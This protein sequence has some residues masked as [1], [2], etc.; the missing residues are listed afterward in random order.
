MKHSVPFYAFVCSLVLCLFSKPAVAQVDTS[1]NEIPELVFQNPVLVSGNALK[2]GA[3]Y[4]FTNVAAGIDGNIRLKKFSRSDISMPS[5]DLT[6]LGW[7]KAFQPQFGLPGNVQP[8]QDWYIDFEL[9]FFKSGSNTKEMVDKFTLTALDVD[10]DGLSIKEYVTMEKAS[11]VSYAAN[12]YFNTAPPSVLI[13]PTCPKCGKQSMPV[14]CPKCG[15]DGKDGKKKCKQCDGVG[16]V[17]ETCSHPWDGQDATVQGPKDNFANIDTSATA[18]MATYVYNNKD[19][20]NFRIGAKSGDYVSN[21]GIRLNSL[22]FK[23]FNLTPTSEFTVL[24][25]KFSSFRAVKDEKNIVITWS[26]ENE[27]NLNHYVI[28]RSTDGNAF[29]DLATVFP[30]GDEVAAPYSYKDVAPVSG[31]TVLYRIRMVDAEKQISYS[32]VAAIHMPKA[33]ENTAAITT[34]PNPTQDKLNIQLPDAWR[35]QTLNVDIYNT[36]GRRVDTKQCQNAAA[37]E[38][39]QISRLPKGT[40]IVMASSK[41]G[42]A[43]QTIYKN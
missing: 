25:L 10:G 24:P 22:W 15:G 26:A 31:T 32:T 40:Y 11:S 36:S 28:E 9:T 4:R 20:V 30:A 21:A 34:Y 38:T 29:T 35:G 19:V 37:T 16:K 17:Y 3:V 8:N 14:T 42:T 1:I 27:K 13:P 18:V 5:V 2:E 43:Q 12:S 6:G 33:P 7:D 41:N 39:V 23:G